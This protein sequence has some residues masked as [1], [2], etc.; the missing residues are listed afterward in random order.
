MEYHA[1]QGTSSPFENARTIFGPTQYWEISIF[2]YQPF[3]DEC[4]EM[5]CT[6]FRKHLHSGYIIAL[7]AVFETHSGVKIH[8]TIESD[9][10]WMSWV[11]I[12]SSLKRRGGARI[13]RARGQSPIF[14]V[15]LE[16]VPPSLVAA[17]PVTLYEELKSNKGKSSLC[18]MRP[19]NRLTANAKS[20]FF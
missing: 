2:S 10:I 3:Y 6:R 11:K 14:C 13:Y 20:N 8:A 4:S 12:C 17:P 15:P 19:P 9:V 5:A 18:Q 1:D 16:L 7:F